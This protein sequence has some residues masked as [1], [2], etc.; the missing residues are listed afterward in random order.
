MFKKWPNFEIK[1][2]DGWCDIRFLW[3]FCTPYYIVY[4]PQHI[5]P[6]PFTLASVFSFSPPGASKDQNCWGGRTRGGRRRPLELQR[7]LQVRG[8][9]VGPRPAPRR[10][11]SAALGW[12][13]RRPWEV[14]KEWTGC[15]V[16]LRIRECFALTKRSGWFAHGKGVFFL[17]W[18]SGT[19]VFDIQN[20]NDV[21]FTFF[22]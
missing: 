1:K 5:F 6:I 18:Y 15:T 11:V 10:A 17:G 8:L 2:K 3:C 20:L 12:G 19:G 4:F 14:L 9:G 16:P 21:L 7:L 13:G 22:L